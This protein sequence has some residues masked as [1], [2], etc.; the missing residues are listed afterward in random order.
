LEEK[1][2]SVKS[3]AQTKK[4]KLKIKSITNFCGKERICVASKAILYLI[5]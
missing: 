5:F 1:K 3:Q 4:K 2:L